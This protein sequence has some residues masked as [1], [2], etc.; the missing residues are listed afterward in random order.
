MKF[1]L[2][3][4]GHTQSEPVASG[5]KCYKCNGKGRRYLK[6]RREGDWPCTYCKGTGVQHEE[7]KYK[8]KGKN[9]IESDV[10]LAAKFG[11]DKFQRV[12][13]VPTTAENAALLKQLEEL[14]KE[15]EAL[16]DQQ[17]ANAESISEPQETADLDPDNLQSMSRRKLVS[18]AKELEIDISEAS[19]KDEIVNIIQQAL[20]VA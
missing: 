4:G 19:N 9:I 8:A 2:L 11:F 16:K 1:K 6:G 12:D 10:D 5:E 20:E 17:A 3:A 14:R 18:L 13:A 7:V 15:N